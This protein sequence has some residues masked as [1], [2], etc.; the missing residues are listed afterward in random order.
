[1]NETIMT[2]KDIF[3]PTYVQ[4]LGALS[5]WLGKAE[6]DRPHHLAH[7]RLSTRLAPDMFPLS[8]QICFACVQAQEG[9][10]RL[11]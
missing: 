3:V 9:I 1:M 6:E 2:L 8:T 10:C 5:G 7:E 4:M 11:R